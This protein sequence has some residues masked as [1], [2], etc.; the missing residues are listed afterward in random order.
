MKRKLLLYMNG[1]AE[2][3]MSNSNGIK[4]WREPVVQC[5]YEGCLH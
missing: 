5:M 3:V 2:G 1:R 4:N